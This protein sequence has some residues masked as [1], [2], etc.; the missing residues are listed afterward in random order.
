MAERGFAGTSISAVKE[1]S[2]LPSGSIYWHFENKEALLGAVIE[3]AATR[4][5]EA[6]PGPET[7]PPEPQ[8]RVEALLDAAARS[9]QD[10]PEFLRLILLISLER[11]EVDEKSLATV[12]RARALARE[13]LTTIMGDL[14]APAAG[15]HSRSALAQRFADFALMVADGAFIAHHVD[16]EATD[17]RAAFDLMRRSLAAYAR[18]MLATPPPIRSRRHDH[19][20]VQSAVYGRFEVKSIARWR[21]FMELLYGLELKPSTRPGEFEAVVDD[22]GSRLLFSEGPAEDLVAYGW[23]CDCHFSRA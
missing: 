23:L 14:L 9:L 3:E 16:S 5:F 17:L 11:R 13:R 22:A 7:L 18:E 19:G 1:R 15:P 8:K 20:K 4:W 12:R 6:L 2:G 10:R 21:R